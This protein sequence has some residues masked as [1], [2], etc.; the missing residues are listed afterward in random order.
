MPPLNDVAW[1]T[2]VGASLPV[3]PQGTQGDPVWRM[4]EMTDAEL[5]AAGYDAGDY[6]AASATGLGLYA[7]VDDGLDDAGEFLNPVYTGHGI[8]PSL[9][10]QIPVGS[11][12]VTTDGAE[13]L[14][15]AIQSV[16][17]FQSSY[18][19]NNALFVR[20]P[21]AFGVALFGLGYRARRVTVL[22]LGERTRVWCEQLESSYSDQVAF[23][24]D[25]L[26]SAGVKVFRQTFRLRDNLA[27][28]PFSVFRFGSDDYQVDSVS[29]DA[30]EGFQV[31]AVSRDVQIG[32]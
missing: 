3:L 21:A 13:D 12:M 24:G 32:G 14:G 9:A 27:V 20:V 16:V 2:Q 18:L 15:G 30:L 25:Q 8:Y 6:G 29:P 7:S 10:A 31:I 4:V 17:S 1:L 26:V 28:S 22:S 19:S 5:T 23:S 11:R